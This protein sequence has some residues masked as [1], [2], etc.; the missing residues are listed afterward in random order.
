MASKYIWIRGKRYYL[1]DKY[2]SWKEAY[3]QARW[4]MKKN[5]K[6]RY[7]I[8]KVESGFFIPEIKYNLYL[9]NTFKLWS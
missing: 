1:Y 2:N 9:T 4:A 7:Y 3:N 5:P 8:Q 6:N